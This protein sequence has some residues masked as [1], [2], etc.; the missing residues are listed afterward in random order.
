MPFVSE[1]TSPLL[2]SSPL[3]VEAADSFSLTVEAMLT[4]C[5]VVF[6]VVVVLSSN[7]FSFSPSVIVVTISINDPS[8]VIVYVEMSSEA[9]GS[10]LV[11]VVSTLDSPVVVVVVVVVLMELK[12]LSV[13]VGI[14]SG[15]VSSCS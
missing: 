14:A 6:T 13:L 15:V 7:V 9:K 11:H 3:G 4:V 8:T 1:L 10:A 2:S 12:V 5:E